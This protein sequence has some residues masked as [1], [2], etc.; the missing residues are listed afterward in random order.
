MNDKFDDLAK[1]LA[2]SVTR[3]GALK[4]FGVGLAGLALALIGLTDKAHAHTCKPS[5]SVCHLHYQ[6]CSGFCYVNPYSSRKHGYCD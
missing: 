2:Q 3:R 4:Q 5:G 6:C 1:G